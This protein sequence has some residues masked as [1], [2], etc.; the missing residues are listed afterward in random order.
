MLCAKQ[1]A[2]KNIRQSKFKISTLEKN[3]ICSIQKDNRNFKQQ[4]FTD[5][6]KWLATSWVNNSYLMLAM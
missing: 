4:V 3:K 2:L 1:R 5:L 6:C